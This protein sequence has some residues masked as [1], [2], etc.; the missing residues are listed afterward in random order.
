M[1]TFRYNQEIPGLVNI[2]YIKS[3]AKI[4]GEFV[5]RKMSGPDP[6]T[7]CIDH[8]LECH[9]N[10]IKQDIGTN[11]VPLGQLRV[12][13]YLERALLF[14]VIADQICLPVALVRGDYGKAWIEIALP[15]V[16]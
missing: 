2:R 7:K 12:G 15:E 11:I 1:N 4:L 9:L 8:Q 3:R 10:E 5:A 13:S 6:T 14:K 16:R